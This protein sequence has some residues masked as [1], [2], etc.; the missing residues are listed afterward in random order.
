MNLVFYNNTTAE[1]LIAVG[2][3]VGVTLG[4]YA[5]KTVL[6]RRLAII[7]ARTETKLDDILVAA[8]DA[9]H[10]YVL[11][12]LGIFF[13]ARYLTLA[14]RVDLFLTR[15][16]ITVGLIQGAVWIDN[17]LRGWLVEYRA[18][19]GDEPGRATSAAAIGFVSRIVLWSVLA[20]ML[21][22]NLGFNITTLVASLGIGGIAVALAVQNILG[23]L[24][25]SLSI[26]LDKPF[27]IGDFINVNGVLGTVEHVG[28]KTTRVRSLNGE[29]IIFSN[30]DLLKSRIHN[31]KRMETRRAVLGIAVPFGTSE[32]QLREIPGLIADIIKSQPQVRLD[33][34]HFTG[35]G[36]AS[37]NF[38]AVYTVNSPDY[39]VHMDI[40]QE[41]H[42]Q[43]IKSFAERGVQFALPTQALHLVDV[44]GERAL[45]AGA[46]TPQAE[47]ADQAP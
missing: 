6:V 42:F 8:L 16:A 17:A 3:A 9:T 31:M 24:F 26:V 23:D 41:I 7:A 30:A 12:V 39:V 25:A 21:L 32:Q 47:S 4:L 34:S 44:N 28:L 15:A 35:V 10:F 40:Q 2:I 33:R 20:L 1:W 13:G 38:E 29:Q 19:R 14:P 27:V 5:L 22:D 36:P 45:R 18:A 11:A 43:L 37:L 46:A